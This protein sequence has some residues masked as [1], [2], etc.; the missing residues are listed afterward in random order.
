MEHDEK[1]K[2]ENHFEAGSLTNSN[3]QQKRQLQ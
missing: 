3:K 1:I 2:I